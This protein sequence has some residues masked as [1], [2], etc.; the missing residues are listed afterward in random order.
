MILLSAVLFISC[1]KGFYE[2][3]YII[4]NCNE[5]IKVT[6]TMWNNSEHNFS[7]DEN[8]EFMWFQGKA[9]YGV[10]P[11]SKIT[12]EYMTNIIITKGNKISKIDYIDVNKWTIIKIS[13][14]VYKSYL[15]VNPEDFE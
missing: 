8:S 11:H 1:D 12:K 2:E 6:I 5:K 10:S 7:V 3:R 13:D 4:N 14:G 9:G 15:F